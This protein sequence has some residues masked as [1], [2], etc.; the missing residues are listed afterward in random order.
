LGHETFLVCAT[1]GHEYNPTLKQQLFEKLRTAYRLKKY[2][3]Y[4][5]KRAVSSM[6]YTFTHG[7]LRKRIINRGFEQFRQQYLHCTKLYTLEDLRKNPPT[8]DAFVVGSDQIWNTTDGI[9]FLSWANDEVLKVSMAASFGA[10]VASDDFCSLIAPWLK[11]FDLVTVRENSG[12]DIC[13]SA[14][15]KDAVRVLDPTLLLHA[16]SYLKIADASKR[17]KPYLFIY[18]LGTRT[19]IDWKQIRSFAKG[20]GL[21]I[22]YVGSQGQEDKYRKIEPSINQWLSLMANAEYVI[23]NSFHCCVFAIQFHKK[24]LAYPVCGVAEKMNDRLTT[25]LAPL[26]LINH[27][28]RGSILELD[29]NIDFCDVFTKINSEIVSA[30]NLLNTL[31]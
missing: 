13:A 22:V 25:L 15:R 31:F 3:I 1:N 10:R 18:F 20:K 9:Y 4:F 24:F 29:S 26:G 5:L 8:A 27:I 19:N 28:Y 2:P 30:K 21:E 7:K 12:V 23:T 14:G 16:D 11:R 6:F 17:P